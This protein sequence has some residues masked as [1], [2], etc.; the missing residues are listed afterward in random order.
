MSIKSWKI[1]PLPIAILEILEKKSSLSD[2]E[3]LEALKASSAYKDLSFNE[4]NKVLM[5]ME[6]AGLIFVSSLTKGR[7]L[8][9]LANKR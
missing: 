9:Q 6:I 2:V 8:V 5:R 7:R 4:L 1:Q 3:L